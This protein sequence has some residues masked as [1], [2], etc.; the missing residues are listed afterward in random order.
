MH[1]YIQLQLVRTALMPPPSL[2]CSRFLQGSGTDPVEISKIR[3]ALAAGSNYCG[4]ILNYKKDGTPFWNLLTVAPIKDEDG[5]VLKFIGSAFSSYICIIMPLYS[6][7]QHYSYYYNKPWCAMCHRMQVE[8]SKY[9]EGSKDTALRPN[10]LPESLI[11]YDGTITTSSLAYFS[12]KK[13][14]YLAQL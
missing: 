1:R 9:T 5:R 2:N 12:K 14:F 3:Q 7:V 6:F 10:G 4:R 11:K 13:R 8:V